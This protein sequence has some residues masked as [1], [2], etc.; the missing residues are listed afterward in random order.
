M[1]APSR[2]TADA[3]RTLAKAG[4]DPQAARVLVR[5]FGPAYERLDILA[6]ERSE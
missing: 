6:V 3:V 2:V 4:V 5:R 1:F